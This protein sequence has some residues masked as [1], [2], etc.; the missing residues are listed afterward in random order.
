[1]FSDFQLHRVGGPQV[2]PLFGVG[3]SNVIYDGPGENED[4][5]VE[6][7]TGDPSLRYMFR[8]APLRNLAAAPAFFHNGAFG[9]IEAAIRHHLDVRRS[10]FTYDPD[11][12][13]LP[14]D[15]F[16]GPV[17]PVIRA[18]IDPLLYQPKPLKRGQVSDL[19]SFISEALLDPRVFTFCG[20]VPEALPSGL[21]VAQFQGCE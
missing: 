13:N 17:L 5:G 6:Q 20:L 4:F 18:G 19:V 14:A 1:M 9:S 16:V 15:L 11:E 7:T 8:T 3:S 21:P 10:A 2:F 12:N